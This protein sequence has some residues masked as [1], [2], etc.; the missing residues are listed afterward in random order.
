MS[1]ECH[2]Y[3]TK[4]WTQVSDASVYVDC[5]MIWFTKVQEGHKISRDS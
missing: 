3:F 1:K 2:N 4:S 5:C